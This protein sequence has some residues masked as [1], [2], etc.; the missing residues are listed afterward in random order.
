MRRVVIGTRGSALATWQARHVASALSARGGG[1]RVE[2]RVIRTRG[3]RALQTPLHAMGDKGLFTREIEEALLAGE[4]DLAVHSLKD[5]PTQ[6]P[7]GLVLG[8]VP[9]REDPADVVVS[10][11]APCLEALPGGAVVLTGSLRRRAQVLH[12]RPDLNVRD[13]R[14]NV[15][16]RLRKLDESDACAIVLARA[17]L[18][19]LGLAG[20]ISRRLDPAEFLPACGQGALAVEVRGDDRALSELLRSIDHAASRAAVTAERA[21]LAALGG[22]CQ[23]PIGAYARTQAGAGTLALTGMVANLDGSRLMRRTVTGACAAGRGAEDLGRRLA[24][25]LLADGCGDILEEVASGASGSS[26]AGG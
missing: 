8:A 18:V 9:E 1:L 6:L 21:L 25:L 13:V 23:V 7:D 19:R 15:P 24:E 17:G 12:R 10:K 5:L 3:D 2:L 16:T 20:R 11:A 22:G 14:G 26:E 4:V